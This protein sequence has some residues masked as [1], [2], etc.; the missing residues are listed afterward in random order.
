MQAYCVSGTINH[1]LTLAVH[2]IS[3]NMAFGH[4]LVMAVGSPPSGL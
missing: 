2:E 3:H 1:T 4:K